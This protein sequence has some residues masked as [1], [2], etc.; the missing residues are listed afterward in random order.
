MGS[1]PLHSLLAS[2]CGH[3][4]FQLAAR[5]PSVELHMRWQALWALAAVCKSTLPSR[6]EA[7]S[8]KVV[9]FDLCVQALWALAA[10]CKSTLPSRKEAASAIVSSAKKHHAERGDASGQ[11]IFLQFASMSDQLYRLCHHNTSGCGKAP[12]RLCES[13]C[14]LTR[15]K[16]AAHASSVGGLLVAL[17]ILRCAQVIWAG[18]GSMLCTR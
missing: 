2:N 6:K 14:C 9:E 7:A 18:I 1:S 3:S 10:V 5:V 11:R 12:G 8:A 15:R 16:R 13:A 4:D 17:S